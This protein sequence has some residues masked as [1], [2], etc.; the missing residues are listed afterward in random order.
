MER[1]PGGYYRAHGRVD[2]T[3]NLGG[4]KVRPDPLLACRLPPSGACSPV[5][6]IL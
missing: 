4:I 1:L 2:D 6:S 5:H 3:M